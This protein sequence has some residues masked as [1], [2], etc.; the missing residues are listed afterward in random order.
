MT[1]PISEDDAAAQKGRLH[2][3]VA[4]KQWH[5]LNFA[6]TQAAVNFV[7]AAPAQVAGEVSTTTRNDGTVG[8]FYFL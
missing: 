8:L 7:N 5:F 3:R 6:T 1:K 2:A 4:G